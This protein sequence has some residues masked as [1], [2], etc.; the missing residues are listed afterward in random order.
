MYAVLKVKGVS[1]SQCFSWTLGNHIRITYG[2]NPDPT[3]HAES[4]SLGLAT[5]VK[6]ETDSVNPCLHSLRWQFFFVCVLLFKKK[7]II[8]FCLHWVFVTMC[9]LSLVVVCG[10]LLFSVVCGLLITVSSLIAEHRL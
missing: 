3:S 6:T 2:K 10:R 7:L 8:Y 1:S 9:G 4:E 5:Q